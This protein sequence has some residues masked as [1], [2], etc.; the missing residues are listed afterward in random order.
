MR[1]PTIA[2]DQVERI[3][4]DLAR[5]DLADVAEV[6]RWAGVGEDIDLG[7]IEQASFA[8]RASFE[9]ERSEGDADLDRF[10]ATAAIELAQA[11]EDV[12]LDVLD[13]PGFW[14]YLTVAHF[15]WL[16]EWREHKAFATEDWARIRIYVDGTRPSECV[17]TR[18]YIRAR[19]AQEAGNSQLA[20]AV[21]KA[22]DFWR[23]HIV[24]VRTSYW[25][26]MVGALVTSQAE[27]RMTV[28]PLRS[29]A[30]R[31]NRTGANVVFATYDVDEARS[32]IE[33]LRES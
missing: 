28:E 12:P 23:S 18:M 3:R 15:W 27:D 22:A 16:V 13:D 11:L 20:A 26:A 33:E 32:L 9:I 10:E 7:K 6:T 25:P 24:R 5:G 2:A 8:I 29:F 19:I 17:M 4:A 14:R 1:Y 30:R 21:P 31:L